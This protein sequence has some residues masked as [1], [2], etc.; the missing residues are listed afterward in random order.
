MKGIEILEKHPLA[1]ELTKKWFLDK[2]LASMRS[3][4][5]T[6]E[7]KLY[8]QEKSIQ[9]NQI[10]DLIDI[11]PRILF[12]LFDEHKIYINIIRIDDCF[13]FNI[14]DSDQFEIVE[15]ETRNA[16]ELEAIILAFSILEEQLFVGEKI[17]KSNEIGYTESPE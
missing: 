3:S 12:D 14:V 1:T 8:L 9:L 10:G 7:F 5:I 11:N 6:E 17:P 13:E 2:M 4:E 16:A 15:F